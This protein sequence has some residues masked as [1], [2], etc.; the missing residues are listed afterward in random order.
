[1]KKH[2]VMQWVEIIHNIEENGANGT[3]TEMIMDKQVILPCDMV[4]LLN[5]KLLNEVSQW[6]TY[7]LVRDVPCSTVLD[8]TFHP[9]ARAMHVMKIK[10]LL[11]VNMNLTS[12]DCITKLTPESKYNCVFICL[13]KQ[14]G[15]L[16]TCCILEIEKVSRNPPLHS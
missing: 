6:V 9:P 13:V 2:I 5:S 16:N 11:Q 12:I 14:T 1:M 3:T 4:K 7:Y 15:R 8:M 10:L